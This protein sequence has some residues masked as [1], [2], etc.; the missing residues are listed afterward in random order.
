MT[1]DNMPHRGTKRIKRAKANRK[2]R[3]RNS[4]AKRTRAASSRARAEVKYRGPKISRT[5]LQN[6][7]EDLRG[8]KKA[9]TEVIE[10]FWIMP[11][12]EIRETLA[13][14]E[15]KIDRAVKV[16]EHAA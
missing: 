11:E 12:G 2:Q 10:K 13:Q 9:V 8:T 16:L 15:K 5:R 3:H 14:T 7:R 1:G 6:M 4:A